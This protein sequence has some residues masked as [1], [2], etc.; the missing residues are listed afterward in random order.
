MSVIENLTARVER[1]EKL[2]GGVVVFSDNLS[3]EGGYTFK[4]EPKR[5]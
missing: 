1:L 2:T 4:V 5:D 3:R